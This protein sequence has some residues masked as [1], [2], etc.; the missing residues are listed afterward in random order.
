MVM[1]NEG[2]WRKPV[3]KERGHQTKLCRVWMCSCYCVY[4]FRREAKGGHSWAAVFS[5][6]RFLFSQRTLLSS[7]CLGCWALFSFFSCC[8]DKLPWQ[9]QFWGEK[10][11]LLAHSY[12]LRSSMVRK[13]RLQEPPLSTVSRSCVYSQQRRAIHACVHVLSLGSPL[14][15]G[16][17][18]FR[19]V[20]GNVSNNSRCVS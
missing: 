19:S 18:S 13:S 14:L 7:S 20:V 9:K 12:R 3:I 6:L 2:C 17:G 11:Y 15:H 4:L 1:R 5:F 16:P 10:G 8:C